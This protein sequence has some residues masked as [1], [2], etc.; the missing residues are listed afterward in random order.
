MLV[1]ARKHFV[2]MCG[3]VLTSSIDR[4]VGSYTLTDFQ[5]L[6]NS[7]DLTLRPHL[8]VWETNK[9]LKTCFDALRSLS[10][11]CACVQ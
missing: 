5:Y 11:V 2:S 10:V 1:Y 8:D 7:A 3:S 6:Y 4:I 9:Y